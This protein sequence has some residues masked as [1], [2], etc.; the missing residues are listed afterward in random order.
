VKRRSRNA[1]ERQIVARIASGMVS[2]LQSNLD[3]S[4]GMDGEDLL[5]L[6]I[7]DKASFRAKRSE[8]ANSGGWVKADRSN[9]DKPLVD[10]G[11]LRRSV[12]VGEIVPLMSMPDGRNGRAF[13]ITIV[14]ADYGLQQAKGG[15][16][17]EILLGRTKAIRTA[18][19]FGD[20]REGYDFVAR[21]N[22]SV[23]PRPWNGVTTAKLREIANAAVRF[24]G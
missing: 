2:A 8:G 23:P 12:K 11:R 1:L 13:Q 18:R 21:K 24:G 3:Q 9:S 6:N 7:W 5:S 15:V 14:A 17:D 19:N 4:K 22:V 10:T 20:L 16:F